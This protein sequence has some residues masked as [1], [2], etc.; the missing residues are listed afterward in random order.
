MVICIYMTAWAPF[1]FK[2]NFG[3]TLFIFHVVGPPRR[4]LR[5][6]DNGLGNFF[7]ITG[8]ILKGGVT[9]EFEKKDTYPMCTCSGN[10]KFYFKT[11]VIFIGRE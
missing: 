3:K 1:E 10:H 9:K 4:N 11:M 2:S 7:L 6:H 5:R 8:D